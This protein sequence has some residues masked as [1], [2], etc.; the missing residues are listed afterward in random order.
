MPGCRRSF[1]LNDEAVAVREF[2]YS[3]VA[4]LRVLEEAMAETYGKCKVDGVNFGSIASGL[5]FPFRSG[6]CY[7][8]LTDAAILGGTAF[9]GY[10][11]VE[12]DKWKVFHGRSA[13]TL[14]GYIPDPAYTDSSHGRLVL[15]GRRRA[16]HRA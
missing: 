13:V 16:R 7:L 2:L 8:T 3:N 1:L 14:T 4:V 11:V 9:V 10:V 5:A 6:Y 15:S 12:G